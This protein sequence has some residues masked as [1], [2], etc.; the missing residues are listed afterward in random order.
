MTEAELRRVAEWVVET[1]LI[2]GSE[3]HT[4]YAVAAEFV[5]G[6]SR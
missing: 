5:K 6:L 1:C 4:A 3:V 2:N